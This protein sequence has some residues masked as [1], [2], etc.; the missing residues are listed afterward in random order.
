[1]SNIEK[2]VKQIENS[3]VWDIYDYDPK[4]NPDD[5]T[6]IQNTH[7]DWESAKINIILDSDEDT[8]TEICFDGGNYEEAGNNYS[9]VFPSDFKAL[10]EL[11]NM[12]KPYFK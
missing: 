10:N 12:C 7:A 2:L 5:I 9:I 1:M 6:V 8:V 4:Y 3:Q 11:M